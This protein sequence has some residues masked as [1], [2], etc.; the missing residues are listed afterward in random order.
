MSVQR[1]PFG[2]SPEFRC[3]KERCFCS[4]YLSCGSENVRQTANQQR[5]GSLIT[6]KV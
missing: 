5:Q 3:E 6:R 4:V 2:F 1:I